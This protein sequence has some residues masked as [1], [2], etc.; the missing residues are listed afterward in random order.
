MP[1]NPDA[2]KNNPCL[3]EQELSYKCLDRNNYESEKCEVYF[4]N[5][6]NCKEFWNKVKT[7]RRRKGIYPHLPD[8]SDREEIK[9]A[10]MKTKNQ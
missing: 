6:K 7:E 10:Y 2:E 1:K 3:K 8:V 4:K 5:Y 9:A